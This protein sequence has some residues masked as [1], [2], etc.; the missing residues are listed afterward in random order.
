ME[1]GVVPEWGC[2]YRYRVNPTTPPYPASG[3]ER[4]SAA[5]T[6]TNLGI[7]IHHCLGNK[8]TGHVNPLKKRSLLKTGSS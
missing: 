3:H 7:L 6:E 1:L 2:G 5:W 8:T 4:T